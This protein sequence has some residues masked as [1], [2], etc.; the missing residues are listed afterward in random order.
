MGVK[1]G[2]SAIVGG[3][4][5]PIRRGEEERMRVG[6]EIEGVTSRRR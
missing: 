3:N 6:E 2:S 5:G 1:I 4:F